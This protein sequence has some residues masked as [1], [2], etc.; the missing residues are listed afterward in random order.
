ML[1]VLV[2]RLALFA[3]QGLHSEQA[4]VRGVVTQSAKVMLAILALRLLPVPMIAVPRLS[5]A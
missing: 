5:A 3:V 1:P 4:I 2:L